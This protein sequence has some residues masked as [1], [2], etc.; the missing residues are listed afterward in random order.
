VRIRLLL[1]LVLATIGASLLVTASASGGGKASRAAEQG[2]A[3]KGGTFRILTA[4]DFDQ[5]DPGV[6]YGAGSWRA[7]NAKL[8]SPASPFLDDVASVH[9]EGSAT[10]VITLERVAPDFLARLTMPFF[11]AVLASTPLDAEVDRGPLHSAGAYYLAEWNRGAS[12][13]AVRNP[14]W[15][16]RR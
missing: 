12:A 11:S 2:H 1:S 15:N 7:I 16:P 10:L 3:R 9:M 8:Q 14:Y 13:L 6:A 5:I 4:S